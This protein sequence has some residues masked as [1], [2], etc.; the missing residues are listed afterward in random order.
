MTGEGTQYEIPEDSRPTKEKLDKTY[1]VRIHVALQSQLP[2][3]K[4]A[5]IYAIQGSYVALRLRVPW[6]WALNKDDRIGFIYPS[7]YEYDWEKISNIELLHEVDKPLPP[8]ASEPMRATPVPDV[9]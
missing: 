7:H 8:P 5:F 4:E 6:T 1:L 9:S 3:A 2:R